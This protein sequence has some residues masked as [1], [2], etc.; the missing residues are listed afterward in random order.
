MSSYT[1]RLI[2]EK[3]PYLL[4]HAHNPVNWYPWGD[5]AFQIARK[6]DKPVLVSIG[7]SACHWCHVMEKESFQDESVAAIM[8]KYFVNIK[9]DREERPD[10]DHLYMEAVQLITGSGGWPLNVFLTPEGKPFYGGT[11]FPPERMFNRPSWT[12]VLLAIAKMYREKKSEIIDQANDLTRHISQINLHISRSED[13]PDIFIQKK[14]D[15]VFSLLMK[16]ADILWGGFESAPKFPMTSLLHY[17]FRYYFATENQAA[18]RQALLTLDKMIAGGIYDHIGGGFARY[19]VDSGWHVPHFEKMLYDNARIVQAL[20]EAF[21]ITRNEDYRQVIDETIAFVCRELMNEESGFYSSLDADSEGEEG[22]YYSWTYEEVNEILKEEAPLFC[23]YYNIIPEGNWEKAKNIL[24]VN[25][26]LKLFA[27]EKGL[28]SE[29]FREYLNACRLKLFEKRNQRIKPGLD[30]KILLSWNALMNTALSHAFMAT[31]DERYR[32]LA[33]KNMQFIF[34]HFFHGDSLFHFIKDEHSGVPAFLDDYAFLIEALLRLQ[35][36]TSDTEWLK[37]AKS[38][39][40]KA[41]TLF[42]DESSHFFFYS[43][44]TATDIPVRT[45]EITDTSTPSGNAVMAFNLYH[46]GTLFQKTEWVSRA[47]KMLEDSSKYFM[48]HPV[49]YGH[50]LCLWQE[51]ISGTCEIA[52][53]GEKCREF[54]DS[55]LKNHIPNRILMS[56]EAPNPAFPTLNKEKLPGKISVYICR[57]NTCELPVHSEEEALSLIQKMKS[58]I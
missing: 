36:I 29:S 26:S 22:K 15:E 32:N 11:Y 30:N 3:S 34:K 24:W 55:L 49:Y 18:L 7:Y 48:Q 56:A 5:E 58:L 51:I 37:Q 57:K 41:L 52:V 42:G 23:E 53:I 38:L 13:L 19:A 40:E 25:Q 50:W 43:P 4:Q 27:E 21:Q 16:R 14:S 6:E 46:L 33:V 54:A 44:V 45:K 8:N 2:N 10:L 1:N 39:N 35:E 47:H 12:E 31:G 9:I 20:S 17:L 28:K